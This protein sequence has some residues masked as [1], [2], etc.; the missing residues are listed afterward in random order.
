MKKK[1]CSLLLALVMLLSLV[2][3]AAVADG[4]DTL[5]DFDYRVVYG[6]D[7]GSIFIPGEESGS[8]DY[9]GDGWTGSFATGEEPNLQ[10]GEITLKLDNTKRY[11]KK[12]TIESPISLN[13]HIRVNEDW[14]VVNNAVASGFT[15]T[16]TFT[17]KTLTFTPDDNTPL[18]ILV[19]WTA[20]R[21]NFETFN[22]AYTVEFRWEG[23]G[24]AEVN[25]TASVTPDK[26]ASYEN[27][28]RIGWDSK[29][30]SVTFTV[31]PNAVG[32]GD[33]QNKLEGVWIER[34]ASDDFDYNALNNQSSAYQNGT[35]TL[36]KDSNGF[37]DGDDHFVNMSFRFTGWD[38][39]EGPQPGTVQ[40]N[41]EGYFDEK[42]E[43]HACVF[44]S[45]CGIEEN[46]FAAPGDPIG[47]TYPNEGTG[48]GVN[49]LHFTLTPELPEDPD[50]YVF[51]EEP[52]VEIEVFDGNEKQVNKHYC[53]WL[54]QDFDSNPSEQRDYALTVSRMTDDSRFT[55]EFEFTITLDSDS[56]V[57]VNVFWTQ[58]EKYDSLKAGPGEVEAVFKTLG[59]IGV[60]SETPADKDRGS[61]FCDGD[62]G[63]TWWKH[64]YTN[65]LGSLTLTITD[66]GGV[67]PAQFELWL[68][69]ERLDASAYTLVTSGSTPGITYPCVTYE[70]KDFSKE[71]RIIGKHEG[72]EGLDL[73]LTHALENYVFAYSDSTVDDI[74]NA[75]ASELLAHRI[76]ENDAFG[77]QEYALGELLG[78]VENINELR[79][80]KW[81]ETERYQT[82][83]NAVK[84]LI[85]VAAATSTTDSITAKVV[86]AT[87]AT[88]AAAKTLP[89]R[90]YTIDIPDLDKEA[91]GNQPFTFTGRVYQLDAPED[92]LLKTVSNGTPAYTIIH[93]KGPNVGNDDKDCFVYAP[94]DGEA[95]GGNPN[96]EVFGNGLTFN[97]SDAEDS[98]IFSAHAVSGDCGPYFINEEGRERINCRLSV[99]R[100]ANVIQVKSADNA[101]P[102]DFVNA[103][104]YS[105]DRT[106]ANTPAKAT[107]FFGSDTVTIKPVLGGKTISSVTAVDLP[108]G[109]VSFAEGT[110]TFNTN[111]DSIKLQITYEGGTSTYLLLTRVGLTLGD[112]RIDTE[113][114]VLN[115]DRFNNDERSAF[116]T[117]FNNANTFVVD[118]GSDHFVRYAS[119]ADMVVVGS[120]YYDCTDYLRYDGSKWY[121][122]D[123]TT[124]PYD[125]KAAAAAV[126][127]AAVD[128]VNL[129]VTVTYTNNT[130]SYKT[131]TAPLSG[132]RAVLNRGFTLPTANNDDVRNSVLNYTSQGSNHVYDD[133]LLWSGSEDEYNNIKSISAIVYEAGSS[134][135]FGGV[136]VGSGAGVTWTR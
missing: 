109:A 65:D 57:V 72:F 2:P 75:M 97:K 27:T 107:V 12:E 64:I 116:T 132:G 36:S 17:E 82:K 84:E 31:T 63:Y 81:S 52:I 131:I 98:D 25:T 124:T 34:E 89:Y 78:L 112:I 3:M 51:I 70:W 100:T 66:D 54:G 68:G 13:A 28:T 9:I 45:G 93:T 58:R 48:D 26:T 55:G 67:D 5:Q 123:D 102:W 135:S 80:V 43:P 92:F 114:A 96:V 39:E 32:T 11:E 22:A 56:A 118:H 20:E 47:F 77:T 130:V 42:D 136:Q 79:G 88:T 6:Q 106:N 76:G 74:K 16:Y 127:Y 91:E 33:P 30:T 40:V 53:S 19:C 99:S 21:Y 1:V 119:D 113:H 46:S 126:L 23:N 121:I 104:V 10:P 29:P 105:G 38:A 122:N 59:M 24:F 120:F 90:T 73:A 60:Y 110:L 50:D 18:D 61:D 62:D 95:K 101:A 87:G 134:G 125:T 14:V 71:L 117:N 69:G 35:L 41:Y 108:V 15:S 4:D 7:D 85:S 83:L 44:I 37:F 49:D 129:F 115:D 86:D 94:F 8:W 103:G 128:K 111:Y 133:F